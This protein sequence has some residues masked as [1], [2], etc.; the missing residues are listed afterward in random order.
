MAN[1][2]QGFDPH[3]LAADEEV[4]GDGH[5]AAVIYVLDGFPAGVDFD[6]LFAHGL[7]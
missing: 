1:G 4:V 6:A 2:T 5:P 7:E 3:G